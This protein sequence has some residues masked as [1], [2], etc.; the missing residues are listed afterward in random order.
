MCF[1]CAKSTHVHRL[2][3]LALALVAT[4]VAA[5]V[6]ANEPRGAIIDEALTAQN[7]GDF[8]RAHGLFER[9]HELAPDARTLRGMG[10]TS[11]QLGRYT[12]AVEELDAALVHAKRPLAGELRESVVALRARAAA[13][14]ATLRLDIYPNEAPLTALQLDDVPQALPLSRSLPVDP[15][16]HVLRIAAAGFEVHQQTIMLAPGADAK[17]RADLVRMAPLPVPAVKATSSLPST[18][19]PLPRVVDE[20]EKPRAPASELRAIVRRR[21]TGIALLATGVALGAVSGGLYALGNDRVADVGRLCAGQP[22]GTCTRQ[23]R[24]DELAKRSLARLELT[25]SSLLVG[26]IA[27]STASLAMF[28]WN[29][30][31]R[32]GRTLEVGFFPRGLFVRRGF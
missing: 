21:R 2:H 9:A 16:L 32:R 28:I 26:S 8:E 20:P 17:V 29:A 1:A 23:Q 31:A 13:A 5:T 10:V 25:V 27:A 15:G 18:P 7:D 19:P 14:I 11:F 4:F 12:R 3:I 6:Q 24:D 22:G 30:K